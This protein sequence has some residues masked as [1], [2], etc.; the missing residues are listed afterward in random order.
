MAAIYKECAAAWLIAAE[1]ARELGERE[2]LFD[3]E[4]QVK[5]FEKYIEQLEF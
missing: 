1:K 2:L 3:C 4:F 5:T